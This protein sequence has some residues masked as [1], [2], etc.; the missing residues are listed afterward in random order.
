M[1]LAV[2]KG[3]SV[4]LGPNRSV[5]HTPS[6]TLKMVPQSSLC[7]K[8]ATSCLLTLREDQAFTFYSKYI[9]I[10]FKSKAFI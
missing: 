10:P 8:S 6:P 4:N 2:C 1:S 7:K 3:S 5:L 9:A